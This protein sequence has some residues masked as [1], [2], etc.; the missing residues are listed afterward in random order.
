MNDEGAAVVARRPDGDMVRT[1]ALLT[2]MFAKPQE[3]SEESD[4]PVEFY[5][6]FCGVGGASLGAKWCGYRVAFAADSSMR[7]LCTHWRNH[8]ECRHWQ[9][10]LPYEELPFPTDGRAWHLHGSPPC[11]RLTTLQLGRQPVEEQTEA[12]ELVEWYVNLAL[13]VNPSRWSMEQVPHQQLLDLL[14]R[15]RRTNKRHVDFDVFNF[16]ELGVPQTRRRLIAGTPE[17]VDRL[18]AWRSAQRRVSIGRACRRSLPPHTKFVK[19]AN[20]NKYV[21]GTRVLTRIPI[22]GTM[23]VLAKPSY[24]ILAHPVLRWYGADKKCIRGLRWYE[25]ASLQTFPK[26]FR[27]SRKAICADKWMGVGNALPPLVAYLMLGGK[28]PSQDCALQF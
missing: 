26:E 6:L 13:R 25:A 2:H 14:A 22:E 1:Q 27:W 23:R 21:P 11:T 7:A 19:N 8:P 5:D 28:R 12:C 3:Q 20:T 10:E 16:A 4:E 9:V 15:L 17:L 24:A 18:R